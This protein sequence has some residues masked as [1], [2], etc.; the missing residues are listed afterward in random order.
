[1]LEPFPINLLS[2]YDHDKILK[3]ISVLNEKSPRRM[4]ILCE[5]PID[6]NN[7]YILFLNKTVYST[8]LYEKLRILMGWKGEI[9]F[10]G[11][12]CRHYG[13]NTWACYI[14]EGSGEIS[15]ADHGLKVHNTFRYGPGDVLAFRPN[16]MHAWKNGLNKTVFLAIGQVVP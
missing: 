5:N 3:D 4:F 14:I 9:A 16:A 15:N 8:E 2:E 12:I 13:P 1:M 11:T 7:E 6:L 10:N